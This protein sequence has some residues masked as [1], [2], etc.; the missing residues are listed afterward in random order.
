MVGRA[1]EGVA[2]SA[3]SEPFVYNPFAW[4]VQED[5][6]PYYRVLL[7]RYPVYR[8]PDRDW[9][10]LSRFDDVRDAARDW[11]TFSNASGTE[12]DGAAEMYTETFGHGIFIFED[13]P[14]HDRL[15]KVVQR[16]FT[17]RSVQA[18]DGRIRTAV[19]DLIDELVETD[20]VDLAEDFAWR[21]P[22]ST[23][24]EVL[25]FPTSDHRHL[26]HWML[27]LEA[28]H[29]NLEELPASARAAGVELAE[30][31]ASSLDQR[32]RHARDDL[33]TVLVDA[34]KHGDL[35]PD[36]ARGLTFILVLAGIDTSACLMSNT[37]HRLATRPDDRRMLAQEPR[38]LPAAIEEMI[39][40]EAPVQGLARRATRGV[41][42]HGVTI[43]QGGW[44][45]LSWAA[46][47]RDERRFPDPDVLDF[48]RPTQRNLGFGEGIHHCIGA[49]LAR[50]EARIA[51]EVFL[52][53]FPRYELCGAG[54]RLHMHGTRGWVHLPASLM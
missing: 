38:R 13:P 33:L 24:S 37:L 2:R 5:P 34:E 7:D 42:L 17:P 18:F 28:R 41:E 14:A 11:R 10:T 48:Q 29:S 8:T 23:I 30:Y 12:L 15:R 47:N 49:P 43:P 16:W 19:E 39:R 26:L 25:G 40:F 21:L 36:E 27:E 20:P 6:Y 22:I 53:R 3:L 44:V 1:Q 51:L 46:A 4:D 50:L 54:Q 52:A 35:Q 32:R 45:W 9:W 31:I